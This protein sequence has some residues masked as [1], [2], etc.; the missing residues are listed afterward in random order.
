[1]TPSWAIPVAPV[2]QEIYDRLGGA[3]VLGYPIREMETYNGFSQQYTENALLVYN[4]SAP[5]TQ[6]YS[7]AP[8]GLTFYNPDPP[9]TDAEQTLP[10][11]ESG[12]VVYKRFMGLYLELDG[13]RYVGR[14]ISHPFYDEENGWIVQYF[15][16]LGFYTSAIDLKDRVHLIPYGIMDCDHSCRETGVSN[17]LLSSKPQYT[18]PFMDAIEGF[19]RDFSGDPLSEY[20]RTEKGEIEQVYENVIVYAPADDLTQIAFRPLPEM[21]GIDTDQ[22]VTPVSDDQLI[23]FPD[24]G[25]DLGYNVPLVFDDFICAHGGWALSGM[26]ITERFYL[27]DEST[28]RQCFE[29]YC[30]DYVQQGEGGEAMVRLASLGQAF[31]DMDLHQRP[32]TKTLTLTAPDLSIAVWEDYPFL[33]PSQHQMIHVKI[34]QSGDQAPVPDLDS[35]LTV[36]LPDGMRLRFA[37]APTDEVGESSFLLP[38][39][40]V[41]NGTLISY[42]VCLEV[43]SP[44]PICQSDAFTVWSNP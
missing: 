5:V 41:P 37:L 15:E 18:E 2:F 43:Q 29:H 21:V 11:T 22:P 10:G 19:G 28:V 39:L 44:Y 23:F 8:L 33:E 14:P 42:D 30:L 32:G 17:A 4:A 7:L 26:P 13:T 16:N 9:L 36:V 20:Y 6:Q 38:L 1:V 35:S 31:M 27:Q 40:N 34:V 24:E 25:D 12:M 3:E